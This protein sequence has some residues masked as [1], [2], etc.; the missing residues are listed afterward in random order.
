MAVCVIYGGA[1]F[2]GTH[3]ARYLLSPTAA[4][5]KLLLGRKTPSVPYA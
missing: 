1:G 4:L 2:I 5:A 3:L